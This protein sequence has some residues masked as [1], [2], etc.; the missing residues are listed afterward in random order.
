M[1]GKAAG[2]DPELQESD[3]TAPASP[4]PTVITLKAMRPSIK[5]GAGAMPLSTSGC[6]GRAQGPA[7]GGCIAGIVGEGWGPGRW[8]LPAHHAWPRTRAPGSQKGATGLPS[9]SGTRPTAAEGPSQPSGQAAQ[10]LCGV[11]PASRVPPLLGAALSRF[12]THMGNA[13]QGSQLTAGMPAEIHPSTRGPQSWIVTTNQ[14]DVSPPCKY[15]QVQQ[16]SRVSDSLKGG[17]AG[18]TPDAAPRPSPCPRLPPASLCRKDGADLCAPSPV[19]SVTSRTR[20]G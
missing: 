4:R 20:P 5:A 12:C 19:S 13:C 8:D 10:I 15:V 17:R 11:A 3:V 16:R 1:Q 9:G 6:V 14:C 2:T 18:W 7:S